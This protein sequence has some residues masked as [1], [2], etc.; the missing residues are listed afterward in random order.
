MT[1]E[2][3][4]VISVVVVVGTIR[5]RAARL[6]A[7][8]VPE[9]DEVPLEVILVDAAPG[10]PPPVAGSGHP[11]VR[12]VRLPHGTP[13]SAAR[14]RAVELARAP[15]VAF[16]EEHC[17][18]RP[19]WARALARTWEG[20]WSGVGWAVV[21]MN[22]DGGR[23]DVVGMMSYGLWEP[24]LESGETRL[25]PGHNA[26]Y[27]RD[28]LLGLGG[29]LPALFACD[30]VLHTRLLGAGHRFVLAPDAVME[31]LNESTLR[32]IGKGVHIFYRIYGPMRAAEGRWSL[33]RRALYVLATPVIPFYFFLGLV[34]RVR[35][36]NPE[37]LPLLLGHAPFVLAVQLAAALG[38]ARGL[39]FGPGDAEARFTVYELTEERGPSPA[40]RRRRRWRERESAGGHPAP[41]PLD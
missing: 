39:A 5:H 3:P 24:P 8:L 31:H 41:N 29:E 9:A 35:R 21:P 2:R 14:A 34:R 12:T 15:V 30:L 33:A 25:L 36:K 40:G 11:A 28:V 16:L 4:P 22:P 26:S 27:R 7:S 6:L 18:V 20:P 10:D 37:R 1:G 38:Q 19:G 13:F 23:A 17:A 32:S